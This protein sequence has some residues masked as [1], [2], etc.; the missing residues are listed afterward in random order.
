MVDSHTKGGF[1]AKGMKRNVPR[2]ENKSVIHELIK[3]RTI[4]LITYMGNDTAYGDGLIM[5]ENGV[6]SDS[7]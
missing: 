3:Q 2:E 5:F 7:V 4:H 6:K 1:K